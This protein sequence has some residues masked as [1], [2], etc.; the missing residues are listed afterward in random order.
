MSD[1]PVDPADDDNLIVLPTAPAEEAPEN[2]GVVPPELLVPALEACLFAVGTVLTV[3]QLAAALKVGDRE[4]ER[5]LDALRERLLRVGAGV[6]L[7]PVG[8]GW[9]IRTDPRLATWVAAA[10]GGRPVRLSKAA[11][12]TLAIIAFRQPVSKGAVDDIRGVDSGGVLR[13]LSERGL[14]R[15]TGRSD[16]PGRPA[17]WGTTPAFLEMFGLRSL[18]DLPTLRD[19]RAVD[20]D[21]APSSPVVPFPGGDDPDRA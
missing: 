3:P 8:D 19:L 21:H 4:V 13:M 2:D 5:G 17:T 6:R 20:A 9:Q 10:R 12:E 14:V 11:M 1:E 15:V 7:I 16:E 18:A